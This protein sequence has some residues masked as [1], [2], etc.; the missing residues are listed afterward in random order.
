MRLTVAFSKALLFLNSW[1]LYQNPSRFIVAWFCPPFEEVDR[2]LCTDHLFL[3]AE[4]AAKASRAFVGR[5]VLLSGGRAVFGNPT[6]VSTNSKVI[7]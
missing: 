3:Q 1:Q 7:K 5:V 6:P 2:R 4:F